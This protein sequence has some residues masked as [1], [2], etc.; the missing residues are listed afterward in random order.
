MPYDLEPVSSAPKPPAVPAVALWETFQFNIVDAEDAFVGKVIRVVGT[1]NSLLLD[2]QKGRLE[3][4]HKLPGGRVSACGALLMR[5]RQA[6]RSRRCVAPL[7]RS[8]AAPDRFFSTV[9]IGSAPLRST[10]RT[11]SPPR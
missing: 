2:P 8:S 9:Q 4:V 3:K 1:A 11:S 10:R 5:S 7:S 6:D